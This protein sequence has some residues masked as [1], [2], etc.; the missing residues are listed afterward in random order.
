M[1]LNKEEE[2][3]VNNFTLLSKI[4]FALSADK[5]Q[6]YY[7]DVVDALKHIKNLKVPI[8]KDYYHSKM[9]KEILTS[10]TSLEDF[11]YIRSACQKLMQSTSKSSTSKLDVGLNEMIDQVVHDHF[12][13]FQL[14]NLEHDDE[15]TIVDNLNLEVEIN[16]FDGQGFIDV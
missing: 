14:E 4:Y 9:T 5:S 12:R 11:K 8:N 3:F 6:T 7:G 1:F 10:I 15:F 16:M 13:M 2:V